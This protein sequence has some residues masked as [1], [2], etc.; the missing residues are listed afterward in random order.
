M[1]KPPTDYFARAYNLKGPD[2][3]RDFYDDW[4][5]TYD[6][7]VLANTYE[8]PRLVREALVRLAV[9]TDAHLIDLGCGT[10]LVGEALH[11]AGYRT[12]DGLDLSAGMLEKAHAKAV[13]GELIQADLLQPPTAVADRAYEHGVS[14]G[15]FTHTHVGPEALREC[16]RMVQPGGYLVTLVKADFFKSAKFLSVIEALEADRVLLLERA[17]E[18]PYR[19]DL[20]ARLLVMRVT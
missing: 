8:T 13:Y 19:S 14:A 18:T 20:T 11:A 6:A 7:T 15:V 2:D 1:S 9:P 10:G 17:D 4:A 3:A 5:N 16:A 12:I